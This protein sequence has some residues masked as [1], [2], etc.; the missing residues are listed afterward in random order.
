LSGFFHDH[1]FVPEG[2][3]GRVMEVLQELGTQQEG[4]EEATQTVETV[5]EGEAISI[6]YCIQ[7]LCLM[8][9]A[10]CISS[11]IHNTHI[12]MTSMTK[13]LIYDTWANPR[14]II[15][16]AEVF[17]ARHK[18]TDGFMIFKVIYQGVYYQF[19]NNGVYVEAYTAL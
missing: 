14:S 13:I 9:T 17:F 11:D 19:K 12:F 2:L 8:Y 3:E 10:M 1:L 6:N 5:Q 16:H 18:R 7:P 15:D 4:G